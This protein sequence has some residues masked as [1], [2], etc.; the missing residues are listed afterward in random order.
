MRSRSED[1]E[2]SLAHLRV[3]LAHRKFVR[4]TNLIERSLV[5]ERRRT[6]VIPRFFEERSCLQLACA[7]LQRA[8]AVRLSSRRSPL[9]AGNHHRTG[10]A[11]VGAAPPA[12]AAGPDA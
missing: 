12:V 6:K 10:A 1:L 2:A 7:A 9:A 8:E 3:P 5:E 11:P 4:T